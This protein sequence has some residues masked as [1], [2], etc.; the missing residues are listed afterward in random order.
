MPLALAAVLLAGVAAAQ[1]A[2]IPAGL[3]PLDSGEGQRL[4]LE[5]TARADYFRLTT[6]FETQKL[7]SYCGVAS[8]VMVLNA[9]PAPAPEVE[10]WAPF[11]A[12]TQDNVFG[13]EA[14][15]VALPSQVST[16]GMTL[17]Q[18]AAFLRAQS[19]QA[20]AIHADELSLDELR[21]LLTRSLA[22]PSDFIVVNWLRSAVGQEPLG[23]VEGRV[24]G[25]FSPIGAYHAGTDRVLVLDVARYKY[26]PV[27]IEL[28]RLYDAM[29]TTDLDSGKPR[30]LVLV[31]PGAGATVSAPTRPPSRITWL[32]L[33]IIAVSFTLGAVVGA[34]VRGVRT[35]RRAAVRKT[36]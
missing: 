35:R 9:L 15:K 3:L 18:L 26:P 22:D 24:A 14:R 32:F 21:A 29:A 33:G 34:W 28:S 13:P 25:H 30:G 5:A 27:W 8:A 16:G 23:L 2:P 4:L 1:H 7:Q 31:S 36:A 11:R 17:D 19:V 12:F 6:W 10:E 20:R